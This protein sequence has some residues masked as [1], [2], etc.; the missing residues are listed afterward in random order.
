[1]I[2]HMCQNPI[3]ALPPQILYSLSPESNHDAREERMPFRLAK[4]GKEPR[5]LPSTLI[6]LN[7]YL[8][9]WS[10][11]C[12]PYCQMASRAKS[13]KLGLK[14]H[15]SNL[16]PHLG[17]S[18]PIENDSQHCGTSHGSAL[19]QSLLYFGT[20]SKEINSSVLVVVALAVVPAI[21]PRYHGC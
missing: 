9:A 1:M 10:T 12:G 21:A 8:Q 16:R 18:Q 19:E 3:Q 7:H 14:Y 20:P 13:R 15:G 17:S 5:M 6:I 2:R 11:V 4:E